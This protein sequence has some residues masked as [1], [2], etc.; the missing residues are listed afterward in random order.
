MVPPA[1]FPARAAPVTAVPQSVRAV[2]EGL[3]AVA[4]NASK[5]THAR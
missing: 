1:A 2:L 4:T 5:I 3:A